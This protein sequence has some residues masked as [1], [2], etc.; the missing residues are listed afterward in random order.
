M[1]IGTPGCFPYQPESLLAAH[2]G[3]GHIQQYRCDLGDTLP[4]LPNLPGHP[5]PPA[6]CTPFLRI[7][8]HSPQYDFI[9]HNQ[10]GAVTGKTIDAGS[11]IS[12]RAAVCAIRKDCKVVRLALEPSL[13]DPL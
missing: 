13:P 4:G 9:V 5:R 12:L 10:D 2:Y 11:S 8:Q 1:M 3:H 7:S 6:P